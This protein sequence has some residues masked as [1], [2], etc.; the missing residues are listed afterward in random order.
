M[1]DTLIILHAS[2]AFD[3]K[4]CYW[5]KQEFQPRQ[6]LHTGNLIDKSESQFKL[7]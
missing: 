5:F 1:K 2:Q 7:I 4:S 6:I 3:F